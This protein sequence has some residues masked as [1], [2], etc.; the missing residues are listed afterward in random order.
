M[1]GCGGLH[2]LPRGKIISLQRLSEQKS[3]GKVNKRTHNQLLPPSRHY[4]ILDTPLRVS[5]KYFKIPPFPQTVS[6]GLK[7][8]N[9][10]KDF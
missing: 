5:E 3:R 7:N 8:Q 6:N 2:P 9:L 1:E 4:E 10:Q